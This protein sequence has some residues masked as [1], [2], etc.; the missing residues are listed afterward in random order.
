MG[1]GVNHL[2]GVC[3]LSGFA[4]DGEG[5]FEVVR[6]GDEKNEHR[7]SV[8]TINVGVMDFFLIIKVSF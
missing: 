5:D 7:I 3:G 8:K 2:A 1:D 4:I 6:V